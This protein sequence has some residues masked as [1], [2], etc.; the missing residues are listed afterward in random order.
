MKDRE[1]YDIER[2]IEFNILTAEMKEKINEGALRILEEIGMK[3]TGERTLKKFA[4][5]GIVPDANGMLRIPRSLVKWALEAAPK[6][7]TL[8]GMDGRPRMVINQ[9]NRVYFGTHNDMEQIVDYKTN[10]ARPMLLKDIETM[11]KIASN[12]E[13]IDFVLS[14]GLIQDVAPQIQSQMA[15]IESCKYMEKT[16]NFSTN[17]IDGLQEIIDIAAN[18]A[19]G[20]DKLV[21]KPFIFNYCEPIPPLTHPLESTEKLYVVASNGIPTVYMPYCMMGGTA[22]MDRPT[23]LAQCFSEILAGLVITQLVREGTPFIAGSMPSI[24]DMKST[25]A[26]YACPEFH[27]MVAASSEMADYYQ[28]PFYG[29]CGCSDVRTFDQQSAGEI[30]YQILSTLL[31]K[32]NIIHDMG[33]HDHCVNICPAAVVWANDKINGFKSYLKGVQGDVDLELIKDVGPAG[34]HLSEDNTLERF[35]E[36][37][38]YPEIETRRRVTTEESEL[39]SRIAARIDKILTDNPGSKLTPKQLAFLDQKTAELMKRVQ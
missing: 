8:Y 24:I 18:L 4:E 35:R 5:K 37:V 31:S 21:E 16:I 26:S 20:H 28:L 36:E 25:I 9:S 7:I 27:M 11:C 19:G 32:A 23:T 13:N 12:C 10:K 29:T 34:N 6:E 3:I 1:V 38:W 14:V 33:L 30:S 17:D 15:F 22:P 39:Y 2:N